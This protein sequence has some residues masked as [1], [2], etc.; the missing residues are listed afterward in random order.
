VPEP[1][2]GFEW[3]PDPQWF[4][5]I[6]TFAELYELIKGLPERR[7]RRV[8]LLIGRLEEDLREIAEEIARA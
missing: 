4:V 8:L 5:E 3:A 7:Q 1:D 2:D 6:R